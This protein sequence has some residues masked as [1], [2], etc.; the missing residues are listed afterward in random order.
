MSYSNEI[1]KIKSII[2]EM[3]R[4][5]L[6]YVNIKPSEFDV[7]MRYLYGYTR[8]FDDSI[9]VDI[10]ID[11]SEAS[12]HFKND[13]ETGRGYYGWG[14]MYL[15]GLGCEKNLEKA[16]QCFDYAWPLLNKYADTNDGSFDRLIADI[17]LYGDRGQ[18]KDVLK[19]KAKYTSA[20]QKGDGPALYELTYNYFFGEEVTT[21]WKTDK[22]KA[23]YYA[24][25]AVLH[26]HYNF[27]YAGYLAGCMLDELGKK[28]ESVKYF[29]QAAHLGQD[30]AQVVMALYYEEM[31]VYELAVPYYRRAYEQDNIFAQFKLG[32]CYYYG[33][34]VERDTRKGLSMIHSAAARGDEDAQ[35]F[36][37]NLH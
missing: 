2:N 7:G 27:K 37:K 35:I 4:I 11:Y 10:P 23:L 6:E 8:K 33:L 5:Q 31:D 22:A 28:D 25:R 1:S 29:E 17:Y 14:I 9:H 26:P 24:K 36:L 34:S 30:D 18:P 16:K 13:L 21:G 12:K 19:A 20:A 15:K 3:S 32:Y